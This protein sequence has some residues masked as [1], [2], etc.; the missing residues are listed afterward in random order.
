SIGPYSLIT[1]Q[2]LGGKAQGGG[3]RFGEMEVWAL[4][5]HGAAHTLREMLTI[6]SDDIMGRS[7]AFDSIVKGETISQ[8]NLPASFN[9]L[10]NNLRGLALDVELMKGGVG[11][12]EKRSKAKNA[13]N[14]L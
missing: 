12:G 11:I 14:Q 13:N 6:K 1:Q 8:P 10:L 9:V 7:A 3:Q 2:P 5:G 4:L